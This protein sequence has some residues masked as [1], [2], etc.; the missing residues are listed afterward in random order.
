MDPWTKI[1]TLKS[2]LNNRGVLLDRLYSGSSVLLNPLYKFR[3]HLRML[4]GNGGGDAVF[5]D[6]VGDI[7]IQL[8]FALDTT[9]GKYLIQSPKATA[10]QMFTDKITFSPASFKDKCL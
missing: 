10:Q 1:Q 9:L 4:D 6:K 7:E 8:N 3:Q 5:I 2:T